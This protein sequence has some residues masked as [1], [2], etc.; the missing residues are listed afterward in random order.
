[1]LGCLARRCSPLLRC[2]LIAAFWAQ[3]PSFPCQATGDAPQYDGEAHPHEGAFAE[4]S[5]RAQVGR[6]PSTAAR[7]RAARRL[8][9]EL[10][11]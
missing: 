8:L 4:D 3:S 11:S 10:V 7:A 2:H 9:A 6:Q 1:M 5:R